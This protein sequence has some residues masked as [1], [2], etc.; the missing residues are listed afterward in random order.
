VDV[1]GTQCRTT[2]SALTLLV[3]WQEG[4]PACKNLRGGVLAWLSVWT[5]EQGADLHTAQLMPCDDQPTGS[6]TV[7]HKENTA[8]H[9]DQGPDLQ[10][11]L[12]FIIR[13]TELIVRSTYD[14]D[15]QCAEIS[16]RNIL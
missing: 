9:I 2:S 6:T 4:H 10:N 3:G 15:L 1:F 8:K 16:L 11:I 14:G 5:L 7:C 13:L 12:R